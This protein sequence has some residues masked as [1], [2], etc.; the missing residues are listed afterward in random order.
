MSMDSNLQKLAEKL[1]VAVSFCDAGLKRKNYAVSE[2]AIKFFIQALGYKASNDKQIE[3]SLL[4]VENKRWRQ[5]LEPIYV[6]NQNNI[7]I[8]IVS[9]DLS[10][11]LINAIDCNGQKINLQ[12]EYLGNAVQ[13]GLFYKE[14]LRITTP[15]A[16]GYYDLEV[17]ISNKKYTTRLAVAPDK[18][19][20]VSDINQK[21][22]GYAIQLYSLKSKRN[23]G[24]GDFTDLNNFIE[25]CA[26][27]GADIIGI[28]PLNVLSHDYPENASPYQS[29]SREF[30]NPI[31]IDIENVPEFVA[32]DMNEIASI[33]HEVRSSEYIQYNKVYP[34]KIKILKQC[35]DRFKQNKDN[36]RKKAYKEFC[37]CYGKSLDNLAAFQAIYEEYTQKVWGG[38]RAWPQE[39]QNPDSLAV[40]EYVK[41]NQDRVEF[42]KF[43]QF[44]ADRQF[45]LVKNKITKAGLKIG[46]YRDLAVGVGRDSAEYWS[47]PDLFMKDAGTGA[48]PDAFFPAGQKWGLG[49]F[50]PQ[51]LKDEKYTPFIRILRANMQNAGALRIDHVMSLMRLYVIPDSMEEGTYIYYNFEDML[52]LVA[53][54]SCL[55]K[56][57]VVGE[58]IGNVPEGFLDAIA[59][60]NIYSLSILWAERWGC[61]W[62]DFKHPNDYPNNAFASVATHD[63]AP[64]KMWWFGYDIE[65]SRSLDLIPN[66]NEKNEAYH[67]READRIKLLNALDNA[68]VWPED[69]HRSGNYIYGEQYPEGIEEA[70]ERFMAKSASPVFL[71]QLEDI[72]HIEKMQNLP[73]TDID[74]HPNWRLK[75]PVDLEDLKGDI[76]YIRCI[77]AIKKER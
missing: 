22:W 14:D 20:N 74:K 19:Y 48:P 38:W 9:G 34:L 21:L 24:V 31:Y 67:K 64:L 72:L 4:E 56:C 8:D 52:N 6:R 58:S 15:L 65:L 68:N 42:F 75:M 13:N 57:M 51:V 39:L 2:K 1:G 29:I 27:D 62:G 50:L 10:S 61:G 47:T 69:K 32:D 77:Q 3:A 60:K 70:V 16:I 53:L 59:A 76:A 17:I 12:Y 33:L 28:N 35:F 25:L 23:W 5:P 30:L 55:N 37:Q 11:I 63:I 45:T 40:K 36:V 71:A 54:E 43:M 46:L 66:D 49:T 26:Q 41:A 18:C 7:I 73:G 44:E